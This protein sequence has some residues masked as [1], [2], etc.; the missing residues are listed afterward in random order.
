MSEKISDKKKSN[1]SSKNKLIFETVVLDTSVV[2]ENELSDLLK[3]GD[4]EVKQKMIVPEL[5]Y[6]EVEHLANKKQLK[7]NFAMKEIQKLIDYAQQNDIEFEIFPQKVQPRDLYFGKKG[8]NDNLIREVA[9]VRDAT[10]LTYDK[11]QYQVCRSKNI[12]S[13]L[14]YI[15]KSTKKSFLEKY[16]KGEVLSVH[17]K[18]NIKAYAKEGKPG[19]IKIKDIGKKVL[20]RADLEDLI[21]KILYEVEILDDAFIEI[22]RPGSTIIQMGAFRIVILKVPFAEGYEITVVKPLRRLTFDDYPLSDKLKGRI[23]ETAEG[24]LIA[25]KPGMGKTTFTQAL[26]DFYLKDKRIIK[27]IEAPRDLVVPESVTQMAISKGSIEEIHDILLLSRPD[28]TIFDEMRNTNDFKLYSDMRLSGVGMIGVMHAAKSIDAIHR[29]IGRIDLGLIPQ[30]VDTVVFIENGSVSQ[31]LA[32]KMEVRVPYG[33]KDSD[34]AR[35]VITISDFESGK[36]RFEI[37]TFGE[38]TVVAPI[39]DSDLE[40][41]HEDPKVKLAVERV[42]DFFKKFSK[43]VEV[44]YKSGKRFI[45]HV[46]KRIRPKVIGKN[47]Q[48]IEMIEKELG[49]S[50]D[51]KTINELEEK[52][53]K[54]NMAFYE[55]KMTSSSITFFLPKDAAL[56][57]AEIRVSGEVIGTFFVSKDGTIK[58]KRKSPITKDLIKIIKSDP[59]NVKIYY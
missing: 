7:A 38:E 54:D 42:R 47:G 20:S 9:Y 10:L 39:S 23:A 45:V 46:P 48:N 41:K 40:S 28:F 29:F 24:I 58:L 32:L 56:K 5:V 53:V 3:K 34:L 18:E 8:Y 27:T 50:I 11:V 59:T 22:E 2:V 52:Q 30:I 4:L 43:E 14:L 16:F 57:D 12:K 51:I 26:I 36:H 17:F 49:I 35:P 21:T 37:Y 25:G 6:F 33:L 44:E 55:Y 19:E 31:V 13:H 15:K 1:K